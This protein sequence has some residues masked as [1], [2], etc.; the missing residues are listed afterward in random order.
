[1]TYA[2]I[3]HATPTSGTSSSVTTPAR[4]TTGANLI[5]VFVADGNGVPSGT[6]LTD[7][8]GNT[9]TAL[10]SHNFVPCRQFYCQNPTTS[11]SHTFTYANG[12]SF[13]GM[14]MQ[15]FSGSTASPLDV[16]SAN[17]DIGVTALQPGSI[18]PTQ[19]DDLIVTGVAIGG[20]P[21]TF[22]IDSGFTVTDNGGITGTSIANGMAY[23]IQGTAAAVNPQWSW[24]GSQQASSTM[25]SF[26]A[27]AGGGGTAYTLTAGAGSVSITGTAASL[28]R[29]LKIIADPG[30]VVIT[31]TAATPKAARSLVASPGSVVIGGTAAT[32]VKTKKLAADVG[33]VLITGTDA[34]LKS[35]RLLTAAPGSV[36]I[37]GTA[38]LLT[39]GKRMAA[40]PGSFDILGTNA[41]FVKALRLTASSGSIA[42]TGTAAALI[43]ALGTSGTT[44]DGGRLPRG[45]GRKV[46]RRHVPARLAD[47]H[48]DDIAREQRMLEEYLRELDEKKAPQAKAGRP[49][50]DK[51]PAAEPMAPRL[52]QVMATLASTQQLARIARAEL[53]AKED[54]EKA[55]KEH[56]RRRAAATA[57]LMMSH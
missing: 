47:Q 13:S 3:A 14:S 36:L 55:E 6:N 56:Q 40:D 41:S 35:S 7:S 22:S 16:Q 25:A 15:A 38:A 44:I 1:M 4:D 19:N 48:P 52:T 32:L 57:V 43:L 54:R 26:K 42:I 28:L 11:A 51:A 21:V 31:G 20:N 17:G 18:T 29:A 33:S 5:V 46:K 37:S 2:L 27:G 49:A 10:N 8:A 34:T 50:T 45:G 39:K 23:L 53:V 9:W 12:S 24:S 30:S